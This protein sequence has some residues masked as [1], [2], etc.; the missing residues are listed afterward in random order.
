[1]KQD[2]TIPITIKA[3]SQQEAEAQVNLLLQFGAFLKDYN[4][5]NLAGAFLGHLLYKSLGNLS[6]KYEAKKAAPLVKNKSVIDYKGLENALR[7]RMEKETQ[8]R[9][10]QPQV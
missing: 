8:V 5:Q 7:K 10:D 2:F 1:M 4:L 6:E 9:K 3:Y